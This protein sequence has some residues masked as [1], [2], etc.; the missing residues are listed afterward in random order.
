MSQKTRSS[1]R[2][3]SFEESKVLSGAMQAFRRHGYRGVSVRDLEVATGISSGSLYNAFGDKDALFKAAFTHYNEV[4]LRG[5][6]N[7][8]APVEAGMTGVREVFRSL[9]HEPDGGSFGCLITNSA[10]EL[11]GQESPNAL[12]LEAF[13]VLRRT[14]AERLTA[15]RLAGQLPDSV[16]PQSAALQLLALYQGV[17]VLVRGGYD[18]AP[19]EQLIDA[20]FNALEGSHAP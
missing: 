5:R 3:R 14:F 16:D 4:V 17:L 1:G 20:H 9:L 15:A 13:E 7:R 10:V 2:S 6:L 18:S 12:V 11:G 19:L 8:Y